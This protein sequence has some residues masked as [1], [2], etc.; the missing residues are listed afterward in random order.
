MCARKGVALGCF[1]WSE[2]GSWWRRRRRWVCVC[3]VCGVWEGD[4]Q[5][6][7][8]SRKLQEGPRA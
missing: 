5:E 2:N 3:V 6:Q 4:K 8:Q 1:A 7:E